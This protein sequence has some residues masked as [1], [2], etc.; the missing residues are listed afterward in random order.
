MLR[1]KQWPVR[2]EKY[3]KSKTLKE[4]KMKQKFD[5]TGMSCAACS[6]RVEKCVSKLD[7]VDSVAVNLLANSMVVD[8][9]E[10]KL[11]AGGISAAV[12]K[13]GYGAFPKE[14]PGA[15]GV[16]GTSAGGA[17]AMLAAGGSA[18]AAELE[19][20]NMK[21]RLI[22]SI[23]FFIPLFYISMGHMM[24]LP[25]PGFLSGLEN[26]ITYGMAQLVL[27]LILMYINRKYYESGFPAFAHKAPN[28]DSLIAVGSLAAVIYGIFAIIRM[29]HG[30]A[31]QDWALV[32]K[33]HMDMYFESAGTILTLITVGKFLEAR[34]KG[35]TTDAVSRLMDMSPETAL[36]ERDEEEIEVRIEEVRVGDILIVKPGS[37]VPVDGIIVEGA[38]S[39]DESFITGESI[40]VDK[41]VG[42]SVT[43]A[44]I[45]KSGYFK[46]KAERIGADTALS[47]II[48][49]V[50]D[51]GGSKAPIAKLADKIAG[52]FVPAVMLIAVAAAVVWLIAG[53]SFEFA[54]S[55]GIAVLVISCPCALGLA[56]PAAIMAGTGRGAE[57]GVLYKNA[58]ILENS[59]SIDTVVMDK[60]GTLTTGNPGII[61]MTV[62]D[63][64][65]GDPKRAGRG[66][67]VLAASVEK[68]SEHPLGQ[69]IVKSAQSQG[70][71]MPDPENFEAI[72]GKG[73]K[74]K[75]AGKM[76][77]GGNAVMMKEA[78]VDI[79]AFE[80][81]A[82]SYAQQGATPLFF[83]ADGV[84]MGVIAV[85]DMVRA[86]S[87]AA[88]K[89]FAEMGIDVIMLTG[90]NSKTA[91][92]IAEKL[93][94]KHVRSEVLPEDKEKEVRALMEAG[95]RV[96][97]VG[98]GINDAPALARADV[99]IAIGAGTDVAIE[100]ADVVLMKSSPL[101]AVK[102]IQLSR[103][104]IRNVKM[105]LFWA[106]FY[107]IIGIPVAAGILYPLLQ[108]KLNPMVG[109]AAMSLS[110]FCVV[111]NALRLRFFKPS[112]GVL[113]AE[114]HIEQ[115]SALN[116]D[117]AESG[118]NRNV[119][120][121][122]GIYE[123]ETYKIEIIANEH[124]DR[125]PVCEIGADTAEME[126]ELMEKVLNVEG[127]MCMKCVAHVEKALKGVEG[128]ADAKADLDAKTATV[129]LS[130]DV[131]D[132]ALVKAVV[133]EGYEAKM[134]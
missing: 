6:A 95:K 112:D 37:K 55:T 36:I 121:E 61:G 51:A 12:E 8:F 132:D 119:T 130:A 69:A 2:Q 21:R 110:S 66:L 103:G 46:M 20:K 33:Y 128:V 102:A 44:S 124:A 129:T 31:V 14:S 101:D 9:D 108:F 11:D 107:N 113:K 15:G 68:P 81:C 49:L 16:S 30:L 111:T 64:A 92:A 3:L 122:N 86:E 71:V 118:D 5:V 52:V 96:A 89:E 133:E 7:G 53:Q 59:K 50:E 105:N 100:S 19:A 35:K 10:S 109:A 98:D 83:A 78:G 39:V 84:M 82:A 80:A 41:S 104:V 75:V 73:V 127:M 45:N 88:V 18:N 57:L 62:F 32:E 134:A 48:Q 125:G 123:A 93:G 77:T 27:T 24:G 1:E 4:R 43:G 115:A 76:I 17:G 54:L 29:G 94:I 26:A 72:H 79:S 74:G 38:S 106:F 60:T 65:S 91:A 56:T 23:I 114:S 70:L 63:D 99:G 85:A 120:A 28:M 67:L 131:A 97:M 126:V 58:E 116:G 117:D 22:A 90:D 42:D 34:S 87:A 40:P 13:A 25:L 47:K